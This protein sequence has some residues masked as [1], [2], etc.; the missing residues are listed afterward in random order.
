[1][2]TA[3]SLKD[4]LNRYQAILVINIIKNKSKG[5]NINEKIKN[6]ADQYQ[7]FVNRWYILLEDFK[8]S[9]QEFSRFATLINCLRDLTETCCI[10][11]AK[12]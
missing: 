2:L 10:K 1:M 9:T 6:W 5:R 8:I 7:Y 3:S 12:G 11:E 4:R